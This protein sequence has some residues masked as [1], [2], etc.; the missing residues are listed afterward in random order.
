MM[1]L[2]QPEDRLKAIPSLTLCLGRPANSLRRPQAATQDRGEIASIQKTTAVVSFE[3]K[4]RL[5]AVPGHDHDSA[6]QSRHRPRT[7]SVC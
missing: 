5:S 6:A 3:Q 1:P 7:S 2:R 4:L